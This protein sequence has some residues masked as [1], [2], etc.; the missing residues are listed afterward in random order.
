LFLGRSF[1][2]RPRWPH[3][4]FQSFSFSIEFAAR[5]GPHFSFLRPTLERSSVPFIS[6]SDKSGLF[7]FAKS[8]SNL[9]VQIVLDRGHRKNAS[10]ETP[11]M[12]QMSLM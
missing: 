5:L 4:E 2:E 1:S 7:E 12:S 3:L 10:R 6:I 8:L 11:S 9:G